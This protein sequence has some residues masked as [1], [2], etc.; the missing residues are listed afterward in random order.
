[1]LAQVSAAFQKDTHL[2]K[3]NFSLLGVRGDDGKLFIPPSVQKMRKTLWTDEMFGQDPLPIHGHAGFVESGLTLAYGAESSVI[4]H[5]RISAVQAPSL[6]TALRIAATFIA[7]YPGQILQNPIYHPNITTRE[8]VTTLRESGLELRS[9]TFID[10]K[11]V[12]VDWD[13][14]R[15]ELQ[16][17]SPGSAVLLYAGG[18]EPTGMDL[19]DVQWKSLTTIL[20]KR[21]LLPLVIMPDQGMA[22]GDPETDA[23]HLRYLAK[24]NLPVISVQGFD[25]ILGLYSDNP[26]IVSIITE[27]PTQKKRFDVQLQKIARGLYD[28]PS[29]WGASIAHGVLSDKY[30]LSAWNKEI[31]AMATRIQRARSILFEMLNTKLKTPSPGEDWSFITRSTGLYCMILPN[32]SDSSTLLKHHIYLLPDGCVSLG[33]LTATKVE[34]LAKAIDTVVR[35]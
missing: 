35:E 33:C 4:R 26:A 13:S 24:Q 8:T 14:M 17:T 15:Q 1:S 2:D 20:S 27:T 16:D 18:F 9:Y 28:H 19:T 25:S 21:Q 11:T 22:S 30:Y 23:R 34:I 3:M 6:T 12:Q 29:P 32:P 10:R 5:N 31:K 7:H